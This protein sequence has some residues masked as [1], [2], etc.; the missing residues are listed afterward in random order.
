M[1]LMVTENRDFLNI[2][3]EIKNNINNALT[4]IQKINIKNEIMKSKSDNS[5]LLKLGWAPNYPL[6]N[7]IQE[8]I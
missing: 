8:L 2:Y 7:G 4:D 5:G 6:E 1:R 3:N